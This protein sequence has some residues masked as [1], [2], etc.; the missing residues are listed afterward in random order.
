ML[1]ERLGYA[2]AESRLANVDRRLRAIVGAPP[3]I[4]GTP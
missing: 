3:P 2:D 1:H 4:A